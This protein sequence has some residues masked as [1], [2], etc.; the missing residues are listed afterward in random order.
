MTYIIENANVLS[1]QNIT[2][3]SFLV[4]HDR[5]TSVLS[6]FKKLTHMRMDAEPFI[7]TPT[8]VFLINKFLKIGHFR[9]QDN[10]F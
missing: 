6:S 2:T 7:M 4:K 10:I 1:E 8:Y 5:I 3:T 9:K